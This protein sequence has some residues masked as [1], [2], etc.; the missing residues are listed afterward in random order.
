MNR[1]FERQWGFDH[2]FIDP[3]RWQREHE[4]A[5]WLRDYEPLDIW[6]AESV[7][8]RVAREDKSFLHELGRE[9]LNDYASI[10][11]LWGGYDETYVNERLLKGLKRELGIG[12]KPRE[13]MDPRFSCLFICRRKRVVHAPPEPLP[14]PLNSVRAAAAQE[15]RGFVIVEVVNEAG[16]PVPHVRLEV[17]L[18][19]AQV[20]TRATGSNGQ[21]RLDRIP[22]GRC[23][24]KLPD[25]DG[26]SWHPAEGSASSRVDKGHK[27][28]HVVAKGDHLTW[29]A[30]QY[31]IKGWKKLWDAPDNEPL[32][33]KRKS[34]HVLYPG[35]EV[36]IPGIEIHEIV[37]AT[38]QV[39][40][41]ILTKEMVE[42]RLVLQDHNQLPFADEPYELR[43]D[44]NAEPRIGT[45]DASGKVVEQLTAN[46][47]RVEVR[48]PQIELSW[49]FA[50]SAFL[51]RAGEDTAVKQGDKVAVQEAV[52][53][54]QMRLNALGFPCGLADGEMGPK[55]REALALLEQQKQPSEDQSAGE[56]A[57]A[58]LDRLDP[59]YAGVA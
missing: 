18:A 27:R 10:N 46:V 31:G 59:L 12:H 30:R 48:L 28:L 2:I 54:A 3:G 26:S 34:P 23:T 4:S 8:D 40:R 56:I 36:V 57:L 20:L 49:S 21:M 51:D 41:I 37:R 15:P 35:D 9:L 29:I 6:D 7:L 11:P 43:I 24:V 53:A 22:Q 52:M 44:S 13:P 58:A 5:F 50:L 32:R 33:K 17:L 14:V 42:F 19:D 39:H 1:H 45:T 38:D 55:T 47:R 16:E 25:M